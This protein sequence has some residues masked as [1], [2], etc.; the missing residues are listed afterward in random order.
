MSQKTTLSVKSIAS[1]ELRTRQELLEAATLARAYTREKVLR[2]GIAELL[3]SD[4]FS[5]DEV[6]AAIDLAN[7]DLRHAIAEYKKLEL[8][9]PRRPYRYRR[10]RRLYSRTARAPRSSKRA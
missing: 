6:L 5:S 1:E 2:F 4:C 3:K 7:T 10:I 9:P 8:E